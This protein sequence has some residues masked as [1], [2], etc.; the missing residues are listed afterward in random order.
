MITEILISA[1]IATESH[2]NNLAVGDHGDAVGCLQ[3]HWEVIDD[4][5][6]VHGTEF[7]WPQSAYSREDSITIFRLWHRIY[8]PK[9]ATDEQLAR[10]W[11]GGRNGW[12]NPN[13]LKYW[14]KVKQ[15]LRALKTGKPLPK[16][17]PWSFPVT[18]KDGKPY[19]DEQGN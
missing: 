17:K 6:R 2:G 9:N 8:S 18:L 14:K 15:C 19:P 11:N 12:K 4:V 3:I 10:N 5:N 13:T 1:V 7:T 16:P